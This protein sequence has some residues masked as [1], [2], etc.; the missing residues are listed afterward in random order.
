M[1]DPLVQKLRA[2][3][4]V[5]GAA[6][7]LA[8][9]FSRSAAAEG[10]VD[11]ALRIV[12]TPLGGYIAVATP[13]GLAAFESGALDDVAEQVAAA[14]GPRVV[15]ADTKLTRAVAR[16]VGEY[17]EGRR[18]RFTVPLD[19]SLTD[20]FRRTV[21]QHLALHVGFGQTTSYGELAAE[22][23]SP[24]AARA[25]GGAMGSNPLP[26]VVP[27]HRVLAAN[28]GLGGYGGGLHR[29]LHLLRLEGVD[30]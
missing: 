23:G 7:R 11:A 19:W 26:I 1:S 9:V 3:T 27:C 13:R 16:Q 12:D 30:V 2:T 18:R 29:K 17:F 10:E 25:V 6:E 24:R 4:R 14:F 5:P 8:L 28:G 21:L 20:G 15:E 22:A